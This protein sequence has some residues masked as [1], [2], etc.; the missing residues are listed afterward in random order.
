LELAAV[1]TYQKSLHDC[2][3]EHLQYLPQDS[4]MQYM[5]IARRYGPK[6]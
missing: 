1:E 3:Y 5:D 6:D 2:I 4:F